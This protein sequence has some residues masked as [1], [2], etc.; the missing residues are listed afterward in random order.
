MRK[1]NLYNYIFNEKTVLA[2][3]RGSIAHGLYIP[4]EESDEFGICDT[5]MF[6]VY[7]FPDEYY[8]SLEGYYHSKETSEE[9][10]GEL[11]IVRYELR[12]FFHLAAGCNPNVITW[13]WNRTEHYT[14]VSPEGKLIL[15]NRQIFLGKRRIRDAF[16]G[17]AHS[18]L[19]R[20][21]AGSYRGYMGEKRKRLVDKYGY[22]TKNASTLIKLLRWGR[23]LLLTGSMQVYRQ[24]DRDFL[25]DIKMGKFSLA[26]IQEIADKEFLLLE[27]AYAAS[28]LPEVNNKR[29]ISELLV[30]ILKRG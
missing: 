19:S 2:G 24:K 29:K 8:F 6:E 22:D 30:A 10:D 28:K 1:R 14:T 7:R 26:K 27:E 21:T 18:Q 13:L 3:Y 17:Y 11:D 15:K 23:E 12:K 25:L 5:D 20:L 16:G 4:P 9:K